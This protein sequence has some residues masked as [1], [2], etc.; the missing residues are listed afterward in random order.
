ME[1]RDTVAPARFAARILVY[2]LLFCVTGAASAQSKR[3]GSDSKLSRAEFR[4]IHDLERTIKLLMREGEVPGLSIVLIR[5]G[6]IYWHGDFGVKNTDLG[7]RVDA[8]TVFETASLTKPI[9]AYA[10]L[11]LVDSGRLNLDAPLANYLRLSD[12]ADDPRANLLTARMVLS[13]TTGLQ[14]EL[15]PR[16]KLKLYFTPGERFSYSGEGY[17]YLQ[18]VIERITGKP[19]EQFMKEFVF[20]PLGMKS[21]GYLWRKS[22]DRHMASGHSPAGIVAEPLMPTVAKLS[23]LHMTALDYS[24]FVI[25]IITGVGLK[26]TTAASMLSPQVQIDESCVF[27]LNP[28][29]GKISSS[30]K[31]GLGWGLE[32]SNA[33]DAFWHW[34]E[35]RAEFQT[36]AMGFPKEKS[37]IVVFTNSGNGLS[38]IPAIVSKTMGQNHPAF[39]WMGYDLYDSPKKIASRWSYLPIREWFKDITRHGETALRRFREKRSAIPPLDEGQTNT[40]GYLL[41]GKKK[42]E[43]A[44]E[45]FKKNTE[46]YPNSWNAWDSLAEMYMDLGNKELAITY[47]RKSLALNPNNKNAAEMII[48]LGKQ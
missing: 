10:V 12:L 22:Y 15:H 29:E 26:K 44:V 7:T 23:W 1:I 28:G 2:S 4:Q 19:L 41:K 27:C 24:R 48:K 46:D 13:H 11:K 40:L 6:R 37:G 5:N 30:L 25:A 42:F 35:N 20:A 34:G 38:I 18:Q 31:W 33:G 43:E 47:Y 3:E 39:A 17:I 45:V 14:N 9:L 8:L 36:F 16:E 32:Y 21:A